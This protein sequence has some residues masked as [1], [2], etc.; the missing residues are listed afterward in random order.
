VPHISDKRATARK[1]NI[2]FF[3]SIA[4]RCKNNIRIKR[5]DNICKILRTPVYLNRLLVKCGYESPPMLKLRR[6]KKA[7]ADKAGLRKKV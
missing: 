2:F 7:S 3:L 4:K 1:C 6:S 5:A